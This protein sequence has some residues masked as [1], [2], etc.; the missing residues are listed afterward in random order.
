MQ[1]R[2]L[3]V[4]NAGDSRA[5]LCRGPDAVALSEDHTL[6]SESERDRIYAAGG[7]ITNF[8]GTER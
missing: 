1:G 3:Y 4:A 7:L 2:Q 8:S 5:V 6:A